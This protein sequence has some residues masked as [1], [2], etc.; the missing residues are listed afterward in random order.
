M[1]FVLVLGGGLLGV[2]LGAVARASFG[3][4]SWPNS[5]QLGLLIAVLPTA[6]LVGLLLPLAHYGIR[7]PVC[8][9]LV[10]LLTGYTVVAMLEAGPSASELPPQQ[11]P[12]ARA[13]NPVRLQIELTR[14]VEHRQAAADFGGRK[15]K[16][17][18]ALVDSPTPSEG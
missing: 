17:R 10:S 3:P 18:A 11:T 16:H 8:V 5:R 12:N 1:L 13:P 4:R 7:L 6:G 15:P 9:Y 14:R 2:L